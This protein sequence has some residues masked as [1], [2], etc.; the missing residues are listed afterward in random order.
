[1]WEESEVTEVKVSESIAVPA[2]K[3]WALIGDFYRLNDWAPGMSGLTTEGSGV[4]GLRH[5]AV[6]NGSIVEKLVAEDKAGMSY[7][8]AIVSGPMP[9]VDY[10][11]TLKVVPEGDTASRIEWGATF[12]PA[13]GFPE[14]KAE[15]IVGNMYRGGIA[16]IKA[17]LGVE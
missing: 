14:E 13:E 15:R 5:L 7:S 4:G 6:P 3:V 1:M 12:R 10:V 11:S 9:V 2:P 16:A 17:K 8:Y